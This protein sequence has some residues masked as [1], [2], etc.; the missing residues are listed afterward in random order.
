[1]FRGFGENQGFSVPHFQKLQQ[2]S[3]STPVTCSS[4]LFLLPVTLLQAAL[5]Y[6][7]I[8]LNLALPL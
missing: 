3:S 4:D 1:M 7:Y 2:N 5:I 6:L 8:Y